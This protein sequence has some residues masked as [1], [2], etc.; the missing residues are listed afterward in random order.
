ML[1]TTQIVLSLCVCSMGLLSEINH[2][3][4]CGPP[5]SVAQQTGL[6]NWRGKLNNR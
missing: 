3:R 2:Y 1:I 6:M 5:Y 4:E